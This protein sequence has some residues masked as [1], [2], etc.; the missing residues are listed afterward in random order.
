MFDDSP[1]RVA[2]YL[3]DHGIDFETRAHTFRMD[4]QRNA[5]FPVFLFD[6]DGVAVDVTVFPH[7]ALRQAPLDRTDERPQQ[8]ASLAALEMM[9]SGNT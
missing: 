6:A 8:R 5:E 4:R 7:D 3:F 9:L 2:T 1:E